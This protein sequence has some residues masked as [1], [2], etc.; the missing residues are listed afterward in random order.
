VVNEL[1][2]ERTLEML[3]TCRPARECQQRAAA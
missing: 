1:K 3:R 2:F